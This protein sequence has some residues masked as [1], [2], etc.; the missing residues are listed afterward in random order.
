MRNRQSVG[1]LLVMAPWWVGATCAVLAFILLRWVFPAMAADKPFTKA[2]AQGGAN[3]APY[4]ALILGLFSLMS[5]IF[6]K[7]KAAMVDAQTD[8][9]S[10][11]KLGWKEFE[12][13]VGEA[14]RRQG[15]AVDESLNAGP[16]GGVDIVLHRGGETTLV[17]CKQWRTQSVGAPVVRELF[18]V[19]T[20]ERA[21]HAV[22]ITTGAFTRDAAAF[23]EGKPI[24]LV[25]GTQLLELVKSVQRGKT[26]PSS[27]TNETR[28]TATATC[29][30]CG[31]PMVLR[32]AR[33]GANAGNSFWG[34]STYPKCSGTRDA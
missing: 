23:A 27:T 14:Y 8:L 20:A 21:Q 24:E 5:A 9:E 19:M 4:A 34:C 2:M 25:D 3:F 33:R 6:S 32:T 13:M 17:Q 12:W 29:P 7:K 22:V 15:Y 11:R 10:L 18:G 26:T 30:K 1:S 28:D 31:S 16:D